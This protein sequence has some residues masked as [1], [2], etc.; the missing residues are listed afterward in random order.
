MQCDHIHISLTKNKLLTFA[1]LCIIEAKQI[2]ALVKK[3]CFWRIQIFRLGIPHNSSSKTNNPV[4]HIH[5][6]EHNTVPKFIINATLIHLKQSGLTQNAIII[7]F[8]P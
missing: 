8:M 2:T 6:R 4:I 5:D 7:P 3:F 1:L